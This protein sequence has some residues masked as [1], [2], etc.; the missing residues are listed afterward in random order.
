MRFNLIPSVT[1]G[2]AM[3]A[4]R[5]KINALSSLQQ[6]ILTAS[7]LAPIFILILYCGGPIFTIFLIALMLC[8]YQEWVCICYRSTVKIWPIK[9]EYTAYAVLTVSIL[10][11]G[12]TTVALGLS[13]L[14]LGFVIV[15]AI[16][17]LYLERGPC[18]APLWASLGVF[19]V[20]LPAI[21]LIWLRREAVLVVPSHE[22]GLVLALVLQVWATD[23]FAYITGRRFGGPKLAPKISP[24]KT[25]SGLVGGAVASAIVMGVAA[26]KMQFSLADGMLYYGLGF[27]LALVAQAGD[28]FESHMK[29]QA[30]FKD[31]GTLLPGHGGVLDRIDGLLTAAPIFALILQLFAV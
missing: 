30:G 28:L 4:L 12:F 7:V 10:L 24:N 5:S 20:G 19:Y 2:S 23:T 8:A 22:W 17:H 1:G 15:A 31:S 9:L 26:Q 16:A 6:R 14:T 18:S 25:W 21:A 3:S 27:L 11:A 29:R 13:L